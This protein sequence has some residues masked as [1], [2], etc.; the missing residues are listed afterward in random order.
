MSEIQGDSGKKT[1][2]KF[3][4]V[5]GWLGDCC[6]T[7][8]SMSPG[9]PYKA[10]PRCQTAAALDAA[11]CSKCGHVF[12]TKFGPPANQTT[13][14]VPQPMAPPPAHPPG[15]TQQYPGPTPGPQYHQQHPGLIYKAPT[16]SPLMAAM[17]SFFLCSFMGQI[18]NGQAI[19]GI[20]AMVVGVLFIAF[21]GGL[22]AFVYWPVMLIDAYLIGV[23]LQRGQGVREWEFF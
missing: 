21:T 5:R 13:V 6:C 16:H 4:L 19:K 3:R 18:Y 1:T 8:D 11:T 14:F 7:L 12:R 23:K 22:G 2:K 10:C 15:P 17:L 9:Q 20:V